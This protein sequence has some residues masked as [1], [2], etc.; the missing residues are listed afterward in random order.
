MQTSIQQQIAD[1]HQMT[2]KELRHR[3]A[4]VYGEATRAHSKPHMIQ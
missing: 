3:Y 4:D 2:V 1:L